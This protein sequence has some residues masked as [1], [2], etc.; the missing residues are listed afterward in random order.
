MSSRLGS[1][2]SGLERV[3]SYILIVGVIVSLLLEVA[4]II[5]YYRSYGSWGVLL[6]RAVRIQGH[7]F[8]SFLFDLIRGAHTEGIALRLMTAGIAVL[9]LTPFIRVVFSVFYFAWEK[10]S[11]YV[12]ITLFV[13]LVLTLSLTLH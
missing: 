5:L 2:D 3:I 4:G 13:L 9:I 7:D 10:N 1:G 8:F 11:K 12:L 6:D